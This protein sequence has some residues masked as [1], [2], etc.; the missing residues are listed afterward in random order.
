MC[1]QHVEKEQGEE[2]LCTYHANH[3]GVDGLGDDVALLCNVLEHLVE[4]LGLDL[5]AMEL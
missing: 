4:G 5:L 3:L 1:Y 2:G